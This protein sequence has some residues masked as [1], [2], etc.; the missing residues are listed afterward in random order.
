MLECDLQRLKT[1]HRQARQSPVILIGQDPIITFYKRNNIVHQVFREQRN[2]SFQGLGRNRAV[3]HHYDHRLDLSLGQK[4]IQ[5]I[6]DATDGRPS[7]IR[8][9]STMNQVK[10]RQA[11]RRFLISRR[12]PDMQT[13]SCPQRLRIIIT[14]G[15]C[16]MRHLFHG[17]KL[18][19]CRLY[20][21]QGTRLARQWGFR[22][23][24]PHTIDHEII[25]IDSR[26]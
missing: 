24:H 26:G 8:I 13:A 17:K 18:I 16:P 14:L 9:A 22:I 25:T 4:V 2:L 12:R 7:V 5:D 21:Q 19:T 3:G 11:L 23:I 1:T 6:T 20:P 10:Y 15:D